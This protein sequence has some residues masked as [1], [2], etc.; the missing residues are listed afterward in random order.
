M[1]IYKFYGR[2]NV[3]IEPPFN[4][5]IKKWN[6]IPIVFFKNQQIEK[7]LNI[8]SEE[9]LVRIKDIRVENFNNDFSNLK[10]I[11][12]LFDAETGDEIIIRGIDC[13]TI[14]PE[15]LKNAGDINQSVFFEINTEK[16]DKKFDR[17]ISKN[18]IQ[19]IVDRMLLYGDPF[20]QELTTLCDKY[21]I[22]V[23]YVKMDDDDLNPSIRRVSL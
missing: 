10:C 22:K 19:E 3:E 14:R 16:E 17:K 8:N 2:L 21:P 6:T 20:N 1:K 12:I 4:V 5:W 11:E 13:E 9:Y 23:D 7:Y 18:E 15:A